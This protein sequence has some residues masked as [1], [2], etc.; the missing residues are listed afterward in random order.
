MAKNGRFNKKHVFLI[1]FK[2][3]FHFF[4]AKNVFFGLKM[5]VFCLK[6]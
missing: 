5:C 3:E 4:K 6:T 2:T 1:K